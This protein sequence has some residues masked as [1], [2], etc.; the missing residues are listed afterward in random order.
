[1]S[2]SKLLFGAIA[3]DLTGGVE[4]ASTM[5]TEGVRTEFLVGPQSGVLDE[6]NAAVVLALKSRVMPRSEA[7]DCFADAA[8]WLRR[9]SP[10]QLF[11]KYCATFD[12]TPEGNIG[13]CADILTVITNSDRLIFCPSYP[14]KRRTVYNGQLFM[15]DELISD[16]P[17]R[18]DPL[19][20]M[21]EPDLRKVLARQTTYGVDLLPLSVTAEGVAAMKSH[22][23]RLLAG[24]KRYI[25]AD[26]VSDADLRAIAQLTADWILMSGNSTIAGFYP[27]IWRERGVL[28]EGA[29][30][31][32]VERVNGPGVVLAGSCASQTLLQLA[33][34]EKQGRPVLNIDLMDAVTGKDVAETAADWVYQHFDSGEVA[35]STAAPPDKVSE[36]QAKLGR[37]RASALA[38]DILSRIAVKLVKRGLARLVVAGGETSGAIVNA[39][40]IRQITVGPHTRG[41][42]PLAHAKVHDG[43]GPMLALCLKS[44]KLGPDD[45]FCD[46]LRSMQEGTV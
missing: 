41:N 5:V 9:Y 36:V 24:G 31:Q 2:D 43:R 32:R 29:A 19:T 39:L 11:F 34:F 15:G 10:R 21:T 42:I 3:D 33:E 46:R 25:I 28:T 7:V 26:A 27:A 40:G 6:G 38:E 12:S 30:P 44:G 16:S 20:P 13:P 17:K 22:V 1:M 14:D 18:N 37:T 35:V 8:S 45:V 23:E 4:L